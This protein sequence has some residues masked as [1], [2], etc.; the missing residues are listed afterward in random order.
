MPKRATGNPPGRPR[1][2]KPEWAKQDGNPMFSVRLP[3][4]TWC[5]VHNLGGS[6]WI[7]EQ[8]YKAIENEKSKKEKGE[9]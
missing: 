7:R 5:I 1:S 8:V 2:N 4:E 9:K 3:M 6:A